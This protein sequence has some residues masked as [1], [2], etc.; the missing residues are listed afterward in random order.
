M[1]TSSQNRQRLLLGAVGV[2]VMV[3]VVDRAGLLS[4][5]QSNDEILIPSA[6]ARYLDR[7]ALW[8]QHNALTTQSAAWA[9]ARARADDVMSQARQLVIEAPTVELAGARFRDR[10]VDELRLLGVESP[11]ATLL[12]QGTPSPTND[13]DSSLQL[14]SLDLKFDVQS[15]RD[16]YNAIDRLENLPGTLTTIES[17]DVTGPGRMQVSHKAS[18]SLRLVAIGLIRGEARAEVGS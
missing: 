17:V 13:A 8:Q 16:L 12:S 7:A 10:V 14:I 1:T 18:I 11:R 9:E 4:I 5:A 2:L 3:V 15:H 6:R